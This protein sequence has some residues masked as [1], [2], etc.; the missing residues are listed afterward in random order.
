M[1]FE[2]AVFDG[3]WVGAALMLA[4]YKDEPAP[5]WRE[6]TINKNEMR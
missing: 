2:E 6:K 1:P 4:M 5:F 3:L